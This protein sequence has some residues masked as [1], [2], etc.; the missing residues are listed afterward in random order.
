MPFNSISTFCPVR[1]LLDHRPSPVSPGSPQTVS[2]QVIYGQ[3]NP[4]IS[5]FQADSIY[6]SKRDTPLNEFKEE[7]DM[8]IKMSPDELES[9]ASKLATASS[10]SQS[11]ASQVEGLINT[12]VG[13]WEGA[14]RE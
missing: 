7:T 11:L 10:D 5:L 2:V 8:A 1:F 3:P 9:L 13:N 14:A 12:A 6:S 4:L